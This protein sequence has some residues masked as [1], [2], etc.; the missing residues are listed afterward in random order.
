MFNW[1]VGAIAFFGTLYLGTL[2]G[3]IQTA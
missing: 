1:I 2:L 3:L